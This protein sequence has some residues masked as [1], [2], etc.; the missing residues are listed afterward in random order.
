LAEIFDVAVIGYGP[1]GETATATLG[2]AGHRVVAFDRQPQMY[3]LPRMATFDGE[4]SR[5]IQALGRSIDDALEHSS[6]LLTCTF[7]DADLN[8]VIPMDWSGDQGGFAW[9]RSVFQPDIESNLDDRIR[10]LP[11]VDVR[12]G[13]ELFDMTQHDDHVEL[14]VRPKNSTDDAEVETVLARY[15]VG[16]DGTNSLVRRLSGLT[17]TDF[18]LH[19]RWLNFDM[20]LK[21]PIPDYMR[22][23]VLAMDPKRPHMFMPLGSLRE[24]FEFRV[25]EHETEEEMTKPEVVWDFIAEHYGLGPDDMEIARQIVYHYY[26]RVADEWRSGRVFIAGDAAH[27]MTPY[28]GQ[29]GCSA[30]RDGRAIGWR[31]DLVL[32]GVAEPAIL[33]SYQTERKQ[34]VSELVFTSHALSELINMTDPK[35]AE[36]RN[37]AILN[38]LVPPPPPFPKLEGGAL[39]READ[40]SIAEVPGS[41]APQG[42]LR[43][44]DS[45][46]RGDDVLRDPSRRDGNFQLIARRDPGLSPEQARF[47]SSIGGVVAVL[48]DPTSPDAVEDVEG[49]YTA[50]LD[51]VGADAYIMRPDWV[52]FG[53]VSLEA[54]PALLDELRERLHSTLEPS[55][56][57]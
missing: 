38:H 16:A 1:A 44:G 57:V 22:E 47:F 19:E 7:T 41:I 49:V 45:V 5:T 35:A 20:N 28:M 40:G 15:V 9:H 31:L 55:V 12:R 34:H 13:F 27:T 10:T 25:H 54:A 30:I 33:D 4:A 8:P 37:H 32:R 24:R 42:T 56:L 52:V 6:I 51:G 18:G 29:G 3:P 14:R 26:T 11:N 17:F 23:L 36:E 21:R 48:G 46:G 39:H 43:R 53:A 2:T 50:F